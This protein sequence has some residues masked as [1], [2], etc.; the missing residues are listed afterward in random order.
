MNGSSAATTSNITD[1]QS[2]CAELEET[3]ARMTRINEALMDRVERSM[4]MQG[5]SFSLFQAANAL[6]SKVRERTQALQKAMHQLEHT[7]AEL[8]KSNEAAQAASRAKSEFLATMSHEV[9]TPMNG[10]L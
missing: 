7:N 5:N 1:Y 4:D 10:V 9:R 8:V 3:V 2:R 6:E